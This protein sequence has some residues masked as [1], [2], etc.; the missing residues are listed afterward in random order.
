ME[1]RGGKLREVWDEKDP[2]GNIIKTAVWDLTNRQGG[3][4]GE[5]S[6]D[7]Y[8][9]YIDEQMH[10][11]SIPKERPI[12][13]KRTEE[14]RA[15]KVEK[16]RERRKQT[17]IAKRAKFVAALEEYFVDNPDP[18]PLIPVYKFRDMLEPNIDY[19]L[20]TAKLTAMLVAH[21]EVLQDMGLVYDTGWSAIS[22]NNC[23]YIGYNSTEKIEDQRKKQNK[24]DKIGAVLDVLPA[25]QYSAKDLI[26][27]TYAHF[28]E[29]EQYNLE[30]LLTRNCYRWHFSYRDGI[31]TKES[32]ERT[33]KDDN[34]SAT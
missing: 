11:K 28:K 14:Y 12:S 26:R 6:W 13:Y 9:A 30:G 23:I 29:V 2:Q 33:D 34:A 3:Y 27:Y 20:T 7:E 22:R 10:I 4:L 5:Q 21:A 15:K 17:G 8:E 31:F 19:E 16:D 1:V 32:N 18:Q 25:G 24:Y